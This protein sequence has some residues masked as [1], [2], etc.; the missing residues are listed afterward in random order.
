MS[1]KGKVIIEIEIDYEWLEQYG[2][3]INEPIEGGYYDFDLPT[4]NELSEKIKK[5]IDEDVSLD[6]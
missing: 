2:D 4:E 5:A 6:V 3:G 1:R